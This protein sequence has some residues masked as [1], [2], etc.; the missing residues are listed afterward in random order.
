MGKR[1]MTNLQEKPSD[2]GE[3]LDGLGD[4]LRA[5]REARRLTLEDVAEGSKLT[6]G[7]ISKVERNQ[8]T[9]SVAVLV[10][11]CQVLDLS[12][13]DLFDP[14]SGH[15]LVR[16]EE[17]EPINFGGVGLREAFLTSTKERRLQ[18]IH[19]T[20]EPGGGSGN[21]PYSLPVDVEFAYILSGEVR[22]TV[23]GDE[24]IVRAGDAISF[25]PREPHSFSNND[26]HVVAEILWVLSPALPAGSENYDS[27]A[28]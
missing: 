6:K 11:V 20:I 7:Y 24:Q 12:I 28:G 13:G 22:L 1:G 17:R 9:P 27:S 16:V 4:R 23:S 5:A 2:W 14:H 15:S 19:S 25:S 21:E 8:A 18:A 26:A 3:S 10:R